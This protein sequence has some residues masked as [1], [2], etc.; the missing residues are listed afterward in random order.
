MKVA[1][2]ILLV[3][4]IVMDALIIIPAMILGKRAEES[5]RKRSTKDDNPR[6]LE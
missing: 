6:E 3:I 4:T 1:I 2:I 5:I